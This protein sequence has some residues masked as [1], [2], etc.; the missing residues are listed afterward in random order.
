MGQ[1][2]SFGNKRQEVLDVGNCAGR[3]AGTQGVGGAQR[4]CEALTASVAMSTRG[5]ILLK[6]RKT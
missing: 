3:W 1:R 4:Y 6:M 5:S 2:N